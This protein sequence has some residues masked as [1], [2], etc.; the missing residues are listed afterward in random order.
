ML[1]RSKVAEAGRELGPL[2]G[3]ADLRPGKSLGSI[4][5]GTLWMM[6]CFWAD[7]PQLSDVKPACTAL[8][9][10]ADSENDSVRFLCS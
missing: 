6:C 10:S 8:T 3:K 5:E 7:G 9:L 1:A 4:E 2:S